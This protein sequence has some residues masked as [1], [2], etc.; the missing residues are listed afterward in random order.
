MLGSYRVLDFTDEGSL[1]CGQI[2]GDLGA[3]VILVEPPHGAKARAIGPFRGA[4]PDPEGSLYFWTFN[5]NKRGI[6][7][8]LAISEGRDRFRELVTSADVLLESFRP[9]Y[10]DRLGLGWSALS[11][12]NPSLVMVSITPFGQ[13][14]PKAGWAATDLFASGRRNTGSPGGDQRGRLR[15][16]PARSSRSHRSSRRS[17]TRTGAARNVAYAVFPHASDRRVAWPRR[18]SAQRLHTAR[19]SRLQR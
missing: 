17:A 9:G 16:P 19:A 13:R 11:E 2:L 8:D 15:R 14:G 12:T 7:L 6:T 5:R 18:R 3:D 10:L 4:R 1:I